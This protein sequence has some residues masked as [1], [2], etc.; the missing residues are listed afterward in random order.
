MMTYKTELSMI[1]TYKLKY[2]SVRNIYPKAPDLMT[3]WVQ[4]LNTQRGIF[5]LRLG[6]FYGLPQTGQGV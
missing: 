6:P 4:F 2:D 1:C 5:F 3:F